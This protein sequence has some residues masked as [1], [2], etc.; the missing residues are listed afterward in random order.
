MMIHE[1]RGQG[2]F[3]VISIGLDKAFAPINSKLENEP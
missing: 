3:N 2:V 1:Y